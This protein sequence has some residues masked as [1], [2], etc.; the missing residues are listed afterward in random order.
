MKF[1][2]YVVLVAG[3]VTVSDVGAQS[4]NPSGW[5][6]PAG[7]VRRVGE[8]AVRTLG[9][10]GRPVVLLHGLVGSERYWGRTYDQLAR[11]HRLIVPDLLGFGR[12]ASPAVA[13]SADDHADA[14]ADSLRQLGVRERVVLVGH[15]MGT[16]VALRLASRHPELVSS[17][18]AFAP[19]LYRN[20][21]DAEAHL[22]H[23]GSLERMLAVDGALAHRVCE[24]SC[25]HRETA[26]W[27]AERLDPAFPA[28]IARDGVAH[29]PPAYFG[30]LTRVILAAQSQG[31]MPRITAPVRLVASA[32]DKAL[33]IPFLQ[34]IAAARPNVTLAVWP[35]SAHPHHMPLFK[36]LACLAEIELSAIATRRS[37]APFGT[38]NP[39]QRS[40]GPIGWCGPVEGLTAR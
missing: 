7:Q 16:I 31:W 26:A 10:Q 9:E 6:A 14:V 32:G 3:L 12:S 27:L 11:R 5:L 17:V 37:A 15:S 30:S 28:P 33:D 36:P 13:Y 23:M 39:T 25:D 38:L 21:E 35:D 8:L 1:N 4:V 34:A 24:W 2:R 19:V 40:F 29:T 20:T 18:L 22:R